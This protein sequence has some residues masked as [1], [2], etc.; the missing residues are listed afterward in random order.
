MTFGGRN[1]GGTGTYARSL[2]FAL[3]ERRDLELEVIEAEGRGLPATLDWLLRGARRRLRDAQ[4]ELLHCPAVVAPWNLPGPFVVTIH[5]HSSKLF[6]ADHPAEWRAY[7][8]WFLPARARAAARVITGTR[9]ARDQLVG[10]LGIDPGRVAV[11]PYGVDPTFHRAGGQRPPAN[12]RRPPRLLFPGAPAARKNLEQALSALASAAPGGRLA[13]AVLQ[14][15]GATEA[16]FPGHADAIRRMGLTRRVHWLGQIP[17]ARMPALVALADVVVYPS[18]YE[19]FGFPAVEAMAAGTP[20]V[21]S[22]AACL[23]EVV[24]DGGLLVDPDDVEGLRQALESVLDDP[25][26]ADRLSAAGRSRAGTFTW[27]RCAALTV[28][29]YREALATSR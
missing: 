4:V 5:D 14:I 15:S 25:A 7:E 29:V 12:P 20:L 1:R 18:R 17:P 13:A 28:E 21:A 3:E 24:A 8:D 16:D 27:Q 11:T 19:G 10:D 2:Q 22:S 26:L 23:P 9:F 6:P